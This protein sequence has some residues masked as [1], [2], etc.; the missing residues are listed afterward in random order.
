[1]KKRLPLILSM[2]A[3]VVSVLGTTPL[4]Q[5][6]RSA[7]SQVVPLAKT[8]TYAKNAGRLNGH[9]SS[10]TPRVG[11]IP[12]V[13]ATG[14]LPASLGAVGP[15]GS[16]G[17]AGPAGPKGDAGVSGYQRVQQQVNGPGGG[18]TRTYTVSCPGGKNVLGGGFNF[19][20]PADTDDVTV[21][22]S[23]PSSDS[24]W[25][26]KLSNR[27]GQAPKGTTTLSIVCANVSS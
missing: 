21:A 16:A 23:A 17:P 8:A 13:G 11:Q 3:L 4:G 7:V 6:A 9:V 20:R 18:D 14:K 10:R 25:E 1:M 2:T 19:S 24:V 26:F 5:A 22:G 27:T 15:A 12:V